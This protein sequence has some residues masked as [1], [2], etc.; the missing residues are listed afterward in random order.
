MNPKYVIAGRLNREYILP[1]AGKPVL[2]APG[3]SLAYAGGGLRVWDEDIGLLGRVG[4]DYPQHWLHD[5]KKRGFD[6]RGVHILPESVDLREFIGYSEAFEASHDNPV[7]QFARREI[8]F[9]KSLLGY[10]AP[11]HA[12]EDPARPHPTA[13]GVGDIPKEY[14][15]ASA[16]HI[17]PLDLITQGQLLAAFKAGKASTL[18]LDPWPGYMLPKLLKDVGNLL[19]GL[20]A[21]IPS[22]EELH[23]LFWGQ[24]NDLWEMAEALGQYNPEFI[25]IKS[26]KRGQ[27]LYDVEGKKR[28]EIPAY[29]SRMADPTGV[30]DAFCGGFLGGFRKTYDPLEAVLH[31]NVAASLK[32]EGSGA[33]YPLEVLPGLAEARLSVLRDAVRKI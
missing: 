1:A 26:G 22:R 9:P 30:G 3:G 27:L 31:G 13:P 18:T 7:A 2:D 23:A 10:Q 29:D 14:L 15:N 33:F 5:F 11:D 21:F 28:W 8:P 24:T 6:V 4:E 12:Q 16:V 25:V 17:C 20:T 32:A 19:S